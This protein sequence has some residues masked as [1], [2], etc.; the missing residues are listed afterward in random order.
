MPSVIWKAECTL[1]VGSLQGTC[2]A[3]LVRSVTGDKLSHEIPW[4]PA[5]GRSHD[6]EVCVQEDVLILLSRTHAYT[7]D[8]VPESFPRASLQAWSWLRPWPA[9]WNM[10][11]AGAQT[12]RDLPCFRHHHEVCPHLPLLAVLTVLTQTFLLELSSNGQGPHP[13]ICP[14]S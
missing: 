13:G 11:L 4:R 7:R 1:Y 14:F 8:I 6:R 2:L 10:W 5:R 9:R 3:R 12:F